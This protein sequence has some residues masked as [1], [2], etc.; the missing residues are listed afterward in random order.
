MITVGKR[1]NTTTSGKVVLSWTCDGCGTLNEDFT[2]VKG[3]ASA[4]VYSNNVSEKVKEKNHKKA[5]K[6]YN[7]NLKKIAKQASNMRYTKLD[8]KCKCSNCGKAEL[9][10]QYNDAPA[11]LY[12]SM[13]LE[14]L[15]VVLGSILGFRN[16]KFVDVVFCIFLINLIIV[17]IIGAISHAITNSKLKLLPVTALPTLLMI[18]Y[19]LPEGQKGFIEVKP[20]EKPKQIPMSNE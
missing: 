17:F 14:G 11:F 15:L 6:D 1:F 7:K 19:T 18:D 9:W 5:N 20:G 4:D 13:L 8:S 2:E 16:S 3:Y 12:V 10:A